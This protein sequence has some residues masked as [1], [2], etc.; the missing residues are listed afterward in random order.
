M[1]RSGIIARRAGVIPIRCHPR[2]EKPENGNVPKRLSKEEKM[3]RKKGRRNIVVLH[4]MEKM[5]EARQRL[6]EKTGISIPRVRK[7]DAKQFLKERGL[8]AA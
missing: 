2:E 1:T 4:V 3:W 8:L 6:R 7:G 5:E